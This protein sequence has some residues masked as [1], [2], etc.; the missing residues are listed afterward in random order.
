MSGFACRP[1][2]AAA[3]VWLLI[4]LA[5]LATLSSCGYVGD[6]MPPSPHIPKAVFDLGAVQRGSKIEVHFTLPR[7]T[8]DGDLIKKF[9]AVEVEI[10]PEV[11]PF[12]ADAWQA[13]A[14]A[15]SVDV[16]SDDQTSSIVRQFD[17]TPWQGQKVIVAV[18]TSAR[19]ERWSA[20]SNLV[21]LQAAE[22]LERPT[23]KV[24][25]TA[26]GY[27]ISWTPAGEGLKWRIY[28]RTTSFQTEP[29]Q[30]ATADSSP[31]L[32]ATSQFETP[33][34]YSVMALR[35]TAGGPAAES[36]PSEPVHV[37]FPDVYP[38]SVP[39]NVVLVAGANSIEVSWERSPES[40]LKGYY[41][42]RSV[43]DGP[44]ERIGDLLI[45]PAYSDHDVA[46]GK[47]YRYEV[48]AI[49]QK[50]NESRKSQPAEITFP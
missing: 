3:P 6:T 9:E 22:P 39:A 20:L 26:S 46:S 19:H 21:H 4:G 16:S 13:K 45:A 14:K 30:I 49:D 10:G 17:M 38:P 33:Y 15:L 47:R 7:Y 28:R 2:G 23:I 31:Y 43:G 5:A 11:E 1:P 24:I 36:L 40:D 48:S 41:L 42:W 29:V 34:D 44:F 37:D 12:K 8:T 35:E 27:V 32:D 50:G 18:R 25:P